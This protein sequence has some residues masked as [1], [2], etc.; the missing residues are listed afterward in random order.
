MV[1]FGLVWFGFVWFG[2]VRLCL[3]NP[4]VRNLRPSGFRSDVFNIFLV[5]DSFIF[6]LLC[7]LLA[8]ELCCL[9]V[10][11]IRNVFFMNKNYHYVSYAVTSL[12]IML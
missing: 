1:W 2:L 8:L 11:M 10:A 5:R 9:L 6:F 7:F 3:S 4:G 12:G